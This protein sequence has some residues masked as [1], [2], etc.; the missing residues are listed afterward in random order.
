MTI[1]QSIRTCCLRMSCALRTLFGR[2]IK[3]TNQPSAQP[4]RVHVSQLD[5]FGSKVDTRTV[6]V[7]AG[8][9]PS[10][11]TVPPPSRELDQ[12]PDNVFKVKIKPVPLVN[13][14]VI[15]QPVAKTNSTH[16]HKHTEPYRSPTNRIKEAC[17]QGKFEE[18]KK[19]MNANRIGLGRD[20]PFDS[21]HSIARN[22]LQNAI[23]QGSG[24]L[25]NQSWTSLLSFLTD[26][27][28]SS[29]EYEEIL[30]QLIKSKY[31]KQ[32]IDQFLEN[33]RLHQSSWEYQNNKDSALI[34]AIRNDRWDIALLLIEKLNTVT[35]NVSR[36][37]H[38]LLNQRNGQTAL[39]MLEDKKSRYHYKEESKNQI[40]QIIS[41]IKQRMGN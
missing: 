3:Q 33:Q 32:F 28:L 25:D 40:E 8:A 5:T 14:P 12:D 10:P 17:A 13:Q 9:R 4:N 2:C 39:E 24:K 37:G 19:V 38:P 27:C 20:D 18:A 41:A 31:D 22:I 35:L 34:T 21:G 15:D 23:C 30:I 11:T 1:F 26:Q 7:S 6:Q 16:Q 36:Q 29:K